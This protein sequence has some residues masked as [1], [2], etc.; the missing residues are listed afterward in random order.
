VAGQPGDLQDLRAQVAAAIGNIA[1]F[2]QDA[3]PVAYAPTFYPGVPSASE[4]RPITVGLSAEV[5]DVN[6]GLLLVRTARITGH[7]TNPDGSPTT[8]GSVSLM[9]ETGFAARGG[10]G[11]NFGSRVQWDGTFSIA[12]VPPG[13]YII[14]A[15]GDDT[16]M[17]QFATQPVTVGEADMNDLTVVLAPG[18]SLSGTVTFQSTQSPTIPDVNQVRI[19]APPIDF[20]NVGPNP[21]ARVNQDGTF[22]IDGVSAGLHWI[23]TQGGLRGWTLKS[24]TLSGREIIDTPLEVRSGQTLSGISLVFTDKLSEVNGTITD[25]RDMPITEYTVLAF[26]TDPALWRPQARQIRTTR[27]DQNGK[28]QIRGL[29]PGDYFLAPVDPAEQGEWFEPAFLDQ[30]RTG[31]AHLTLGDGDIKTQDFKLT[32]R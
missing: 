1:P 9:P 30:H 11:R 32:L 15:R 5:L 8:A 16:A 13:R 24:V 17:P 18:A 14:R 25:D 27:P 7:V 3:E 12:N 4:A 31:A 28:Y 21:T 6:F 2:A 26:P 19:A 22:T 29:P 10:P 20:I 23:R